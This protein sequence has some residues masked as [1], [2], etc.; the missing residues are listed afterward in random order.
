LPIRWI[1]KT[2]DC[3]RSLVA[4]SASPNVEAEGKKAS[5]HSKNSPQDVIE[6]TT[7]PTF[8]IGTRGKTAMVVDSA[9]GCKAR[10]LLPKSLTKKDKEIDSQKMREI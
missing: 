2:V 7:W 9:S 6:K 10:Y 5:R 8:D 1:K 3:R 4:Q